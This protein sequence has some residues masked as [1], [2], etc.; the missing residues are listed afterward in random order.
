MAVFSKAF[1][2]TP[3]LEDLKEKKKT[4]TT[5]KTTRTNN[6]IERF[7]I[8]S[9]SRSLLFLPSLLFFLLLFVQAIRH[10]LCAHCG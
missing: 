6:R 2:S 4:T 9:L 8:L 1:S 10:Y 7:F 5:N 3:E